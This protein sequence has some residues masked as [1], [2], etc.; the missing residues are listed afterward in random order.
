MCRNL[1]LLLF[2]RVMPC[3]MTMS[4]K[5]I[6]WYKICIVIGLSQYKFSD[7][8][9][10]STTFDELS[11]CYYEMIWALSDIAE[12]KRKGSM[13]PSF[14]CSS[15]LIYAQNFFVNW[16]LSHNLSSFL[17]LL[18]IQISTFTFY[19]FAQIRLFILWGWVCL[20]IV[21]FEIKINR[22]LGC[23]NIPTWS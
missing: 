4:T 12:L 21:S 22:N 19:F 16:W 1:S 17:I 14:F 3:S 11:S 5:H 20:V 23:N 13:M 15:S 10:E 8:Q 9:E 7:Q 18:I 6:C 2:T